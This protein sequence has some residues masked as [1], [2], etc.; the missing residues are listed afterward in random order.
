MFGTANKPFGICLLLPWNEA[1]QEVGIAENGSPVGCFPAFC[2]Y[3]PIFSYVVMKIKV[4]KEKG[5]RNMR[6]RA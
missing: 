2:A 6:V 5:I 3:V 4:N 1:A